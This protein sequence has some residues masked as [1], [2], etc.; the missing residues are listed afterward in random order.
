M[1]PFTNENAV[2]EKFQLD[3]AVLVPDA[4]IS[5]NLADAHAE[6]LLLLDPHAPTNPPDDL[7]VLGETLLAGAYLMRSL[8]AKDAAHQ[9]EIA[10]GGY[11]IGPARRF[12][13]LMQ[14]SAET[15]N[16]AWNALAPFLRRP[17]VRAPA[18]A[19]DTQ[20]VLG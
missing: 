9:K 8:A 16:A 13:A 19:T 3:D 15:E 20:P 7:L 12:A 6:I 18:V 1:P 14:F 11:R 4:L 2:R 10:I 5:R 17:P